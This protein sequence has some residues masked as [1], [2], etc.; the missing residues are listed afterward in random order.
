MIIMKQRPAILLLIAFLFSIS[1]IA[2]TNYYKGEWREQ[3]NTTTLFSCI[4]EISFTNDSIVAGK[5]LW[6]YQS[7]D[8]TDADAIDFYKDK[9]G[10]T[11]IEYLS[12]IYRLTTGD[13]MLM[14]DSID[15]KHEIIAPTIYYLKLSTDK[16]ILFGSTT[17]TNGTDPGIQYLEFI[18]KRGRSLFERKLQSVK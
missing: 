4:A 8:S 3:G 2:Q 14:A 18:E 10:L 12:G 9:K 1:S 17:T 6:T 7:I 16:T 15:D 5:I 11:A 13:V